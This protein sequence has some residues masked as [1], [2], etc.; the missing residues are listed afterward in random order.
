M[1]TELDETLIA[2]SIDLFTNFYQKRL[3]MMIESKLL[4]EEDAMKKMEE[5]Q[6]VSNN[7]ILYY[8][9]IKGKSFRWK[10]GKIIFAKKIRKIVEKEF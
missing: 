5:F 8:D 2:S 3:K 1:D 7:C 9:S 4:T 6:Q 10:E